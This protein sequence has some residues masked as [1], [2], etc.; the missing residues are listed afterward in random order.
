MDA[1]YKSYYTDVKKDVEELKTEYPFTTVCNYPLNTN[2][3]IEIIVIAANIDLIETIHG[4]RNDFVGDYSKKLRIV[5]PHDYKIL[6]CNVYG[7]R[8]IDEKKV[9]EADYHFYSTE[10]DGTRLFCVGVPKSFTNLKNVILENVKTAD[11]MLKAYECLQKGLTKNL[12][13]I[14][15]N[16]GKRGEE[17]YERKKNRYET[18]F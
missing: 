17:E 12:N 9:N 18:K 13:L 14:A 3:P 15:Y 1:D 6:G 7:G 11:N 5:V 10:R 16:H 4:K 2:Q 8:W